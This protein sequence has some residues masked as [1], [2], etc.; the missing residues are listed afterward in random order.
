ME[1]MRIYVYLLTNSSHRLFFTGV[2]DSIKQRLGEHER[3]EFD[4]FTRRFKC[5]K[6]VWFEIYATMELAQQRREQISAMPRGKHIALIQATNP[7]WRNLGDVWKERPGDE[8]LLFLDT[9]PLDYGNQSPP[10][11]L[12]DEELL[13]FDFDHPRDQQ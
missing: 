8:P 12:P 11:R 4:D 5:T 10:N 2:T 13:N 9:P 3:G 7:W 1:D 6:L